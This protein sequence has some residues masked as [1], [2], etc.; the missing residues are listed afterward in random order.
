MSWTWYQV[1]PDRITDVANAGES[2]I[3]RVWQTL[4]SNRDHQNTQLPRCL[5]DLVQSCNFLRDQR[6]KFKKTKPFQ[7]TSISWLGLSSFPSMHVKFLKALH[8]SNNVDWEKSKVIHMA[9]HFAF[10]CFSPSNWLEVRGNS[11]FFNSR[12]NS[13][14]LLLPAIKSPFFPYGTLK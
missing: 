11:F 3:G 4:S 6:K 5:T 13:K 9:G 12:F 14:W 1:I 7:C 8:C 10:V 2:G